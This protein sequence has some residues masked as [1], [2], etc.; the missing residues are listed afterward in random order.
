MIAAL[1]FVAVRCNES[2][3]A[4]LLEKLCMKPIH[5]W[6]G[7]EKELQQFCSLDGNVCDLLDDDSPRVALEQLLARV[8]STRKKLRGRERVVYGDALHRLNSTTCA[9]TLPWNAE[10]HETVDNVPKP[11]TEEVP[12]VQEDNASPEQRHADVPAIPLPHDNHAQSQPAPVKLGNPAIR[13]EQKPRAPTIFVGEGTAKTDLQHMKALG[14]EAETVMAPITSQHG[15]TI[16]LLYVR[17][18]H[19]WLHCVAYK[20]EDAPE[21]HM[22]SKKTF[23]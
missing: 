21:M 12:E 16:E 13:T 15:V 6:Y 4:I 23:V 22:T 11:I 3:T 2:L 5:E 9:P 17:D 14:L 8:D 20:P 1:E 7:K 10:S 19:E 18:S